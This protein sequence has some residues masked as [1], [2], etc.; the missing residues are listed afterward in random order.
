MASTTFVDY[1]NATPI[2]AAWLNDVNRLQY[3]ILGNPVTS[4]DI[5][6]V[7]GIVNAAHAG[8]TADALT[9]TYTTPPTAF[10]DGLVYYVRAASANAT[11]T[12]TF[13]PNSGV[14]AATV[15]VKG[16]GVALVPGD[17]SGAGHWLALQY[18]TTLSKWVLLN[19]ATG[20]V[21]PSAILGA[22][23]NLQVYSNGFNSLVLIS[24]DELVVENSSNLY[25]T[26][27]SVSPTVD[28][29]TVGANGL[30]TGI[31]ATSTWYS[32]WVI[33]NGTTTA[34]LISASPTTPTLPAG[35]TYKTRVGWIR[36]DTGGTPHPLS[37]KQVGRKAQ[38]ITGVG[39]NLPSLPVLASGTAGSA[40]ALVAVAV[41]SVVPSTA[42][43]ISLTLVGTYASNGAACGP[44]STYVGNAGANSAPINLS[45]GAAS[46]TTLGA[47]D[48]FILEGTYP[49]NVYWY[50]TGT[51]Y[52]L[53]TGWV[54]NL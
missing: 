53:C 41:G 40:S 45:Q 5:N 7:L 23:R 36:T 8:G 30:D 15:I 27:R 3:T 6:N 46:A 20:V 31:I 26:L 22:F 4:A 13:T 33:Y 28:I 18:D 35:Y 21:V 54:D 44:N 43:E 34:G 39:T 11:A 19:P 51:S 2:T 52:L 49:Q 47:S 32:V 37:F 42:S 38:Y 25:K 9:A 29:S 17:I 12:P 14:L 24:A 10:I 48:T 16:N 1:S 50:A